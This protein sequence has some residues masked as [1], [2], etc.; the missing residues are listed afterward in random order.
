MNL[1]DKISEE[2]GKLQ[3][4]LKLLSNYTTEIGNAK[5]TAEAATNASEQILETGTTLIQALQEIKVKSDLLTRDA[6]E[7]LAAIKSA[8][9]AD[10]MAAIEQQ[11]SIVDDSI[12]EFYKKLAGIKILLFVLIGLVVV[13]IVILAMLMRI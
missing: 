8:Q 4:E 9:L 13:G 2:L 7:V 11:A 1:H 5:Q 12:Q 3:Q 6:H 10:R